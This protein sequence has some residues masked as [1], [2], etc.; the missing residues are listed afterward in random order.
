VLHTLSFLAERTF[1]DEIR[2]YLDQACVSWYRTLANRPGREH[3]SPRKGHSASSVGFCDLILLHF[4]VSG[5]L[6]VSSNGCQIVHTVSREQGTYT[7]VRHASAI[8]FA[9]ISSLVRDYSW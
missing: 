8:A 1:G 5:K 7:H 6:I 9:S 3:R 2:V 4:Y